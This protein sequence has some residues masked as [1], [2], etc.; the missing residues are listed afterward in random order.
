MKLTVLAMVLGTVNEGYNE[1][2]AQ[3][4]QLTL[5]FQTSDQAWLQLA[6]FNCLHAYA[7]VAPPPSYYI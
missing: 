6:D 4:F 5:N 3:Y 7:Y 2:F 1:V